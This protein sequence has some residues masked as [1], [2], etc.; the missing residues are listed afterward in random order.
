VVS[1]EKKYIYIYIITFEHGKVQSLHLTCVS[2][3]D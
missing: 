3:V 1:L 2:T